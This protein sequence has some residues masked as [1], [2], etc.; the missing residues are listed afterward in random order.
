MQKQRKLNYV[1]KRHFESGTFK[2]VDTIRNKKGKIRCWREH[3]KLAKQQAQLDH[4]YN[5]PRED[6]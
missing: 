2:Y 4:Q 1:F 5:E 3:D 6:R